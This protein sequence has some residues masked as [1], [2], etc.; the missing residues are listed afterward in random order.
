MPT[1]GGRPFPAGRRRPSTRT[2][3]MSTSQAE[4]EARR[5][6]DARSDTTS[7]GLTP[8]A[9]VASK[10]RK[11]AERNSLGA[12]DVAQLVQTAPGVAPRDR[13]AAAEAVSFVFSHDGATVSRRALRALAILL[14]DHFHEPLDLRALD[15][16]TWRALR[17]L[18]DVLA[19]IIVALAAWIVIGGLLTSQSAALGDAGPVVSLAVFALALL[20]LGLLE[21][22][23]IGAASLAT[24]DV[25]ALAA[26][27]PRLQRLHRHIDTK[28]KLQSYLGAR[29]LGVVLVVFVIAEC[30]RFPELRTMPGTDIAIP[31][32]L[33]FVLHLG[34]PGALVVLAV[35]QV[36]P[37]VIAA[38]QPAALMNN[39]IVAGAFYLTLAIGT[40]GLAKPGA[41]LVTAFRRHERIPSAPRVRYDSTTRDVD[42]HGVVTLRRELTVQHGRATLDAESAVEFY[43]GTDLSSYVDSTLTMSLHPQTLAVRAELRRDDATLKTVPGELLD[44]PLQGEW[45]RVRSAA[46][47]IAGGF[48]AGDVLATRLHATFCNEPFEDIIVVD[49]PVYQVL[50]RVALEQAPVPLPPA[51]LVTA[52]IGEGGLTDLRD[53][54]ERHVEPRQRDD[55]ALGFDVTLLLPEPGTLIRLTWGEAE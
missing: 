5:E 45:L 10:L 39:M 36:A 44:E 4:T 35:A 42:R 51:T 13:A 14:A 16:H 1:R 38:Q 23:H 41:W 19:G 33:D 20:G 53:Y 54:T 48:R 49:R 27:H 52:R 17:G 26:S 28:E 34:V 30:T 24:A 21:A 29:Q 7:S 12:G 47:P 55:G 50:M 25:S 3:T 18:R 11:L 9:T 32:A 46:A 43:E 8:A 15:S 31:H 40:L 37:Q 22:A 2:T 6:S